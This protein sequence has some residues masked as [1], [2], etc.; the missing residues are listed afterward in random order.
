[1]LQENAICMDIMFPSKHICRFKWVVAA[2]LNTRESYVRWAERM[3]SPSRTRPVGVNYKTLPWHLTQTCT[4]L[5][6]CDSKGRRHV[7]ISTRVILVQKTHGHSMHILLSRSLHKVK[8]LIIT[9]KL[10]VLVVEDNLTMSGQFIKN[11]P[12]CCRAKE[13]PNT[14]KR[15][16]VHA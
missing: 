6:K 9:N 15:K 1:M 2:V 3:C 7:S 11:N 13:V 4:S 8:S 10:Q 5:N 12:P 14:K 16:S